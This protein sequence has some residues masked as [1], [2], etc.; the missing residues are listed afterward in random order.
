[1]SDSADN[2]EVGWSRYYVRSSPLLQRDLSIFED[3]SLAD[4]P[5][6][7]VVGE[8]RAAEI[9]DA[10]GSVVMKALIKGRP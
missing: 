7:S 3:E 8:K 5:V 10:S 4:D 9:L 2:A 1:M 6:F